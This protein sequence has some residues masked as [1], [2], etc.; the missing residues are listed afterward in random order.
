MAAGFVSVPVIP[1][2]KGMSKEFAERLEKP[3]K[4]SGERA[5]KAMS[6]GMES[7]VEN[8]ERQVKASSSKLQDLDRAYE[9]SASKQ[10]A[11]KEKLEA[12]TLKLQDAE[13][14]YQAA[15]EKGDKGVAELAKVKE[16]KARVIGETE[17]LEQAEIDVRVAEQKHKDQLDD[18]NSTLA[19]LQDSQSDLNRELEKS[20]GAFGSAKDRIQSMADSAKNGAAKFGEFAQKYKF[21]ASAA[22]GGIGMLGKGAAEYASEAEQ[23]YGAVESIFH[24]HADQIN[25]ASKKA[26]ESIGISAHAFREQSAYMGAM[27]K[28]QGVPMDELADKTQELM[29]LGADLAATY[30][31]KTSDAIE[32]LGAM[33]RGETD[34]ME[35]YGVAIKEADI[36]A[37]MAA[38]GLDK[39]EGEAEKQARTQTLLKL[40]FEQTADAQGQSQREFETSAARAQRAQAAMDDMRESVGSMLLPVMGEL[41]GVMQSVSEQAAKHPK[42]FIAVAGAIGTF[43]AAVVTAATVAPIFQWIG[44]T[45]AFAAGGLSGFAAAAWAVIAPIAAVVAA[46]GAVGVALWAFFTKTEVGR[47][48]WDKFVGALKDG[49]DWIAGVFAT[50]WDWLADKIGGFFSWFS[51]AWNGLWDLFVNRDYT[52]AL[53]DVFGWDEDSAAVDYIFRV[54]DAFTGLMDKV[55]YVKSTVVSAWGEMVS[56]FKGGDDGYV[57]IARIVGADKAEWIVGKLHEVGDALSKLPD[58]AS[59]VWDILFKGDYNGLP[60]G[61][62]EDSGVVD[63]L[64]DVREAVQG[65]WDFLQEKRDQLAALL[66]PVVQFMAGAMRDVI[67]SLGDIFKSL[68]DS[69]KS[70]GES[71]GSALGSVAVSLFESLVSVIQSLWK[72]FQ[73]LWEAVKPIGEFFIKLLLPVL[74]V[75][76][77]VIGGVVVGAVFLLVE[78]LKIVAEVLAWVADKFAWLMENVLGP[79]IE[80]LG[81]VAAFIIDTVVSAFT[82]LAEKVVAV[83]TTVLE[84]I[85]SFLTF[86]QENFWPVVEAIL[87]FVGDAFTALWDGLSWAWENVI[88]PVFNGILELAKITIGVIATIILTPLLIA[89]NLLSSAIQWAWENVIQPVWQALSDFAMNTLWPALQSVF[90]WIGDAWQ[91]LSDKFS[92]VWGWIRDNVLNPMVDFFQSTLWPAIQSV[93]DWIVDKWNWLSETLSTVWGWIYANV[94][95]NVIDGFHAIWDAVS[96][97]AGWI[98][99]KW[100]WLYGVLLNVWNWLNENVIERQIRGFHRIWEAVLSVAGWIADKWQW[101]A[102]RLHAGWVWIDEHVFG[103]LKSGLDTVK[104]WFRSTVD[105]IGRIWDGIREKTKKPVEFVVNTVYNNGI[106]SAWNA[107]AGL[108]GLDKLKEIKFATGGI[109]P[110]YT[111]GRD[112]YTF[113]EPRTG[114]R[115]GLSG[116]EAILRPEATRAL[117]KDWVDNINSAARQGGAAGVRNRLKHSH[118]AT[119]GIID[120]GNFASGGFTNLAGALSPVQASQAA[121]VGKFFPGVFN[122]TSA[123][124]SEPGSF[125]DYSVQGAT[126]WQNPATYASQMPSAESKALARAIFKNFHNSAE[127]IHYP[128]DG[129]QNL[130][131][132]A[133]LDYGPGTNAQHTNHVHWATRTPIRFDGKD[134]KLDDVPGGT[135]FNPVE[136]AKGLWDAAINK[137]GEWTGGNGSLFD[138]LPGA[139]LKTMSEAAWNFIKEK[140]GELK[141]AFSG[142]GGARNVQEWAPAATEALR[143]AGYDDSA[144]QAMLEQIYIESNG[145]PNIVNNDDINAVNGT[146]SGGLLQVIEPTYR[147]M[148]SMYPEAFEGLPDNHLD[149]VTNMTA[150]VLWTK[151]KYGGPSNVWPTRAGYASGG[152]VELPKLY[153]QGGWL[154]HGGFAQNLSGKPEPVFTASQWSSIS[155]MIRSLGDLVP[156]IK[157]QTEVIARAVD[158]AQAWLAKAGDYNSIEGINARQGARRVLDLGLDLPGSDIVKMV[159]DGEDTLWESRARATKNLD[160]IVEK[161]KALE[162]ARKAVA[163]LNDMP[164][165]VSED[166]QKKIDEAQKALDDAKAE[167]AKA[168]SDDDRAKAADKVTEAEKKLK[169][170]REE[171]DKNSEENAKKHAEEVTKANDAVTKAEQ[172]LADARKKQAMDLDNVVLLSQGQ[173]KGMIPQAKQLADQLIGMGA[174]AQAVNAGLSQ[175]TGQLL[176]LAGFAGPAGITLGMA[177]DMLKVGIGIIKAIAGAIEDLIAKIRKARLD[178]L[179]ALADGWSIIADYAKLIVDLQGKVTTLQQALI[180]GANAQREAE[181]NLMLAQHDRYIAEAE[182]A[183]K[184]AEARLALDA[185]IKRGATIAQLKMMGLHEDWDSYMAYQALE[186]QGVLEEWSDAAISALFTYEKAR[187]EALKG[188]VSARLEQIKAEAALAEAQRE[189]VRNQQDLLKAQERLIRMSAKVA[190]VDLVDA[191]GTAQVAKLMAEMAEV[192]QAMGKNVFGR[193]GAALGARGSYAN[194]YRGQQAQYKSL[195]QALDAVLAETGV[196]I[197]RGNLDRVLKLMGRAAYRGGDPTAVLR[198]QLPELAQAETALKINESLKPVY[199]ARDQRDDFARKVEDFTAEIDLYEKTTPLEHTL[200]GLDYTIKSLEQSSQAWADGNEELRGEYLAAAKANRDAAEAAGVNWKLDSKY[201]N[202]GVR[203]QIRRETTIHLD[204]EKMYTADQIDQLLAEVTSGTNGSYRIVRSA[205]EVAVSRRKERV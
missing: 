182:G 19:K 168:E 47:D 52:S 53:K 175:V 86:L 156:A 16:A 88:Q 173:I 39:L 178:A 110:G 17:K 37:R 12:A 99:D 138:K 101:M 58:L 136:M 149:P 171:V 81:Q 89:W 69:L 103:P 87:G 187:A 23:S 188:E 152:V 189:N 46:V 74:K 64:F 62:E 195:Q 128:L 164:E 105:N 83:F 127:L 115:I 4:A 111:P 60:F 153:D 159:L 29:G 71:L 38:D 56:A 161:E 158:D 82:W 96:A 180:R 15:L 67:S 198:A 59:G 66:Q 119:G 102:D 135:S 143:R 20:G 151:Y 140:A 176:Q 116:G 118:F 77:A 126:D 21:H 185:E 107:V 147:S 155:D 100:N 91:W 122:L 113:V 192:K 203:D 13:D 97:V 22:L 34:P 204:G 108:V 183:L 120:L 51:D 174:P 43:S 157:G 42:I 68:W 133:P 199:D 169:D 172:E 5:G 41:A 9:K 28:N 98:A 121:F 191:T 132:G 131:D 70:V 79:L 14:K 61:L 72:A 35:K 40:A 200:K 36:K 124:R 112:P 154:P 109:L 130:K 6:Q 75:V 144:L 163:D 25:N 24:E 106:R 2:F 165:G 142:G 84:W 177:M 93:I 65:L 18:L 196:Q 54:R 166:D 73:S 186:A 134:L 8:L 3:A 45:S 125:H 30:G 148:R 1:T 90:Q 145:D 55:S 92:E 205:S 31:G 114:M 193:W 50:G 26:A 57:G 123:S 117:G 162:D 146:P 202:A 167:K 32:A 76:G 94:I 139:Y 194:E 170:V 44:G 7:A 190:G 95:Q 179:K 137:I 80:I 104:G 197:D 33:L 11:Q 160:T 129:W 49:W 27:L 150:A 184:V 181:Y 48:L 78:A 201:A 63:F 141:S 10:A 85:G